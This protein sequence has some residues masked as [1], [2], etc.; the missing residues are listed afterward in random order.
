MSACVLVPFCQTHTNVS[1]KGKSCGLLG[2]RL[3]EGSE[4]GDLRVPFSALDLILGNPKCVSL[5]VCQISFQRTLNGERE[6]ERASV[7]L[8][9][10][11]PRALSLQH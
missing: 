8:L 5:G 10:Q 7:G 3:P 11:P 6:E 1:P 4:L 2:W 9:A